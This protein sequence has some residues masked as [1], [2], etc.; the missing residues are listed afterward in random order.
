MI[1]QGETPWRISF[2]DPGAP[3]SYCRSLIASPLGRGRLG[4]GRDF[5]DGL[6]DLGRDLVGVALR[7]RTAV[8]QIALVSVVGEG[9]RNADR[10][11]TV[12]NAVAELVP[13]GGLVL[14]GQALVVVRPVDGNVVHDILLK[15]RHQLFEV[16]LAADFTHVLG[17]EV[18]V[19]ARAV[20][21]GI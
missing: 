3:G 10:R 18:G 8:F 1:R 21:V 7:V 16:F 11:A 17:R 5:R 19:H 12:G 4:A 13:G 14:A 20:P 6:Q 15:G 9:V 2:A